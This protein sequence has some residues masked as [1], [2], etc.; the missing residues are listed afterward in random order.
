LGSFNSFFSYNSLYILNEYGFFNNKHLN[1][2]I[3]CSNFGVDKMVVIMLRLVLLYATSTGLQR[4]TIFLASLIFTRVFTISEIGFYILVQTI[5]Q[6]LVPIITLNLT[7]ALMREAKV[8]QQITK[9]LLIYSTSGVSFLFFCILATELFLG[10]SNEIAF[11]LLL[12]AVEAIFYLA[13]AVLQGK[14]HVN[15]ILIVSTAKTLGFIAI[16]TSSFCG[17]TSLKQVLELQIML[18]I[19]INIGALNFAFRQLSG[20]SEGAESI[21]I[22]EILKY[23]MATLPHTA[24]LW[25][26]VSS[27]RILLGMLQGNKAIGIYGIA[28]TIAQI[29]LLLVTGV[30]TSLPPRIMQ[31]PQMWRNSKFVVK[32]ARQIALVLFAVIILLLIG[33]RLNEVF[34]HLIPTRDPVIY[35]LIALIGVAFSFS[36]YYVFFASYMYLNRKTGALSYLGL[37]IGTVNFL[38]MYLLV[39]SF[40]SVGAAVGLICSYTL[41]GAAYGVVAMRLE[42]TLRGACVPLMQLSTLF[43]LSLIIFTCF[44]QYLF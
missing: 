32:M 9:K 16:I 2:L 18:G 37:G 21:E 34:F 30:T 17:Y 10:L 44:V 4:G 29:V 19:L 35:M 12:G 26:S 15:Q 5:S 33:W 3:F 1:F 20:R 14:E 31:D 11:G 27:D 8:N 25:I 23:S 40:G 24:A 43:L 22:K 39:Y 36:I 42:P 6:L 38:I 28:F 7:V 41:F 13:F